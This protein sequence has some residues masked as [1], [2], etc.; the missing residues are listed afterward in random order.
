MTATEELAI[1]NQRS[2]ASRFFLKAGRE[3]GLK[4]GDGV[5]GELFGLAMILEAENLLSRDLQYLKRC[6]Q[7]IAA[8]AMEWRG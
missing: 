3:R 8:A 6:E 7:A 2:A 5:S 1:A 4:C